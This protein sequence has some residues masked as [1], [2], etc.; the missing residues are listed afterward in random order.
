MTYKLAI[1]DIKRGIRNLVSPVTITAIP[2]NK[3]VR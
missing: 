2:L 1:M 3:V